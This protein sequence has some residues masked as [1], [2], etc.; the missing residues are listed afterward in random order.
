MIFDNDIKH[1]NRNVLKMFGE[2]LEKTTMTLID[3]STYV[4]AWGVLIGGSLN[5]VGHKTQNGTNPQ[6]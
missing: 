4:I 3:M 6:K 1:S 5:G 2:N